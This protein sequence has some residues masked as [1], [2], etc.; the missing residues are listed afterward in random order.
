MYTH[1]TSSLPFLSILSL[2]ASQNIQF[3][4]RVPTGTALTA[5]DAENGLFNSGNVFG[6]NLSF[7][8]LLQL[9]DVQGSIFD[10]NTVPLEVTI[11]YV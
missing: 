4:G 1:Y 7:S 6:Q 3:D 8:Q 11:R 2:A 10:Q 5:F 9:P